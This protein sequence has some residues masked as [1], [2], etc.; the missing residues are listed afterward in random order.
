M[1]ICRKK[2]NYA[3]EKIP[4]SGGFLFTKGFQAA[5]EGHDEQD[6]SFGQPWGVFA[7]EVFA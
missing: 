4:R 2:R 7:E 6:P 1:L 3:K 5:A